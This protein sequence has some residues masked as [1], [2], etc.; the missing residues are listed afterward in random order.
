[1]KGSE[2]QT[3]AVNW[4]S[5]GNMWNWGSSLWTFSWDLTSGES[6]SSTRGG[7]GNA[8]C[9][10][11]PWSRSEEQRWGEDGG[12][13]SVSSPC[14]RPRIGWVIGWSVDERWLGL[15]TSDLVHSLA[16]STESSQPFSLSKIQVGNLES[17]EVLKL[18]TFC[19]HIVWV[20]RWQVIR[21]T[22]FQMISHSLSLCMSPEDPSN[23]F[24]S[25]TI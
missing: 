17:L 9:A 19:H 20:I 18:R 14:P 10:V 23:H 15:N 7:F 8:N 11:T 22:L 25:G 5:C 1:M 21:A 3:R 13:K 24:L 12:R 4:I 6:E 16:L 2:S